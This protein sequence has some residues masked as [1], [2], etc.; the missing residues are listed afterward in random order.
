MLF[1]LLVTLR[2]GTEIALVLA[3]VLGYLNRT[4]NQR[5][6]RAIWIGA[7][8][9]GALSI[10]FAGV[11]QFT[12]AELSGQAL[13]AFEGITMLAAVVVLTWMVFWTRRQAAT[14]GS[15]LRGQIDSALESGSVLA[16]VGLAFTAVARE[17]IETALFLFAGWQ[18]QAGQGGLAF[19]MGGVLGFALSGVLGVLVYA[20]SHRLPL[21]SFFL[22]SGLAVLVLSA[23]LLTNGIAEL[24]ES[25]LVPN[26]GPR[27]W[28]SEWLV[29]STSTL[30]KFLHTF[31]GYDSSPTLGQVIAYV[32]YLGGGLV[33]LLPDVF[34]PRK[35]RQRA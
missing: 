18:A 6:A 22:A 8:A 12:A 3:I 14:I 26:L 23:G 31:V 33:I 11:L 16:L 17:G 30:G 4:Q 1:A 27:P 13:E 34:S 24:Q 9:A 35:V 7:G 25:G 20:G 10:A 5:H 29:A 28:D 21:R 2:E 19:A 15:D 32:V